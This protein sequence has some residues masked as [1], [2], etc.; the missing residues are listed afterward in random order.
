MRQYEG[1][2]LFDAATVTSEA[3]AKEEVKRLLD[4]SEAEIVVCRKWE[5]RRLAYEIKK[6]KRGLYMLAF[7][8][9]APDKVRGLE[10]DAR[11]SEKVLRLLVLR[12]EWVTEDR[13]QEMLPERVQAPTPAPIESDAKPKSD[14]DA[15][16]SAPES[17]D[18]TAP[19]P[20]AVTSPQEGVEL[21]VAPTSSESDAAAE[22]TSTE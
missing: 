9:V 13:I 8:R 15:K 16:A 17:P 10:R 14:A 11:L 7:F 12:A 6:C 5:E 2:F 4:R 22:P 21:N 1:M 3:E 18:V 20:E 19:A